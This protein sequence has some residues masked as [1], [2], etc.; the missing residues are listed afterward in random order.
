MNNGLVS[1]V[2]PVYNAEKFLNNSIPDILSQTYKN[3]ELIIVD[4]GSSDSSLEIIKNFSKKDKR[5]KYYEKLNGGTGSALNL[6][7][8]YATGEYGTWVS[9]DDIKYPNFLLNLVNI[10]NKNKD[11]KLVFSAFDE[12]CQ[13][14]FDKKNYRNIPQLAKTGLLNN[15]LNLSYK[16][17]ITG[18]CF[19]FDMQLK[20][21][22]GDYEKYA[23]EDYLMGVKM[24]T[25]TKVYFTPE[26]LGAHCLHPDSL[27]V[28]SP[29]CVLEANQ[30]V[31][32]FIKTINNL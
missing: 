32:K 16:H 29:A 31:K 14:N 1:V 27:T 4:D 19:M 25:L 10:L 6:G 18:I 15:F 28:K 17:C 3:L 13:N 26:S 7:F 24:A 30:D 11:C 12:Y 9:A 22:C 8:N 5:I 2:M 21:M 23:G 20:K